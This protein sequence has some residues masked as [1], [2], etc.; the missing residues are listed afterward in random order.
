LIPRTFPFRLADEARVCRMADACSAAHPGFRRDLARHSSVSSKGNPTAA[1]T[2]NVSPDVRS[3]VVKL[4]LHDPKTTT[5][6][7]KDADLKLIAHGEGTPAAPA[8]GPSEIGTVAHRRQIETAEQPAPEVRK[9]YTAISARGL[10][11]LGQG[12]LRMV[13]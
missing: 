12:D 13:G 4:K 3:A 10:L 11:R 5:P 8:P 1:E 2:S 7:A 6:A 9:D